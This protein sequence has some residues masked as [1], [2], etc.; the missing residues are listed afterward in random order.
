MAVLY[1]TRRVFANFPPT[2]AGRGLNPRPE[3]STPAKYPSAIPNPESIPQNKSSNCFLSSV[4]LLSRGWIIPVGGSTPDRHRTESSTHAKYP[5]TIPN[6]ESIPQNKSSNCFLPSVP[7]LSRGWIIP[8]GGSTPD[9]HRTES[10][11]HA[12]YLPAIPNPESI[13]QNKSSNCFLPSVPLLSRGWIIPVGGSTPDR[14]K[15]WGDNPRPA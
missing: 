1:H 8:V 12:K 3:R 10:S 15:V 14:L 5:P 6:P 11:T 2:C 9:R 13:P 4:P 7:L